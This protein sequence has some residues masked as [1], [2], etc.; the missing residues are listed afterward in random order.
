MEYRLLGR[1]GLRVAEIG[2]GAWA[3][4]GTG[5]GPQDDEES[6]RA[7]ARY[8]EL[9]GNF[10][11]TARAYGNG[12]SEKLIGQALRQRG[13]RDDVVIATKVPPANWRWGPGPEI[14]LE[15]AFTPRHIRE[16]CEASLRDLDIETI[17]VLQLHT[18][19]A[20]FNDNADDIAAAFGDLKDEGKIR[21]AGISVSDHRSGEANPVIAAGW[22]DSI[23]FVFNILVQEPTQNLLPTARQFDA[24]LIARVP[25]ASGALSGTWA[26]DK[27]FAEGDHRKGM[28]QRLPEILAKVEAVREI[29]GDE[30]SLLHAALK[31]C[32]KPPEV[33]SV[34]P[35]I[36]NLRQAEDNCAASGEPILS[37]EKFD[38]LEK[39]ARDELKA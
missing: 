34:I 12:H 10:I 20:H 6:L 28:E 16:N 2:F 17:D 4:G 27:K 36:R 7:L 29:I 13:R 31:F 24:G 18:W 11:D 30:M 25:L 37:A 23:Q 3:I 32:T 22:V 9:G 26:A 19:A 33:S 35:G 8:F 5:W 14:P 39:L 15:Q 1:T 38:R 21:A